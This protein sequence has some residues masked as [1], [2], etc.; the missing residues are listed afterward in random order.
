MRIAIEVGLYAGWSCGILVVG[1]RLSVIDSVIVVD[2]GVMLLATFTFLYPL[3]FISA[4]SV[5]LGP[6]REVTRGFVLTVCAHRYHGSA[7][8]FLVKLTGIMSL[9]VSLCVYLIGLLFLIR[10]FYYDSW[11][12]YVYTG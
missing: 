2:C 6:T 3:A 10:V 5:P 12:T 4:P 8:G 7:D 9:P 1:V 11:F